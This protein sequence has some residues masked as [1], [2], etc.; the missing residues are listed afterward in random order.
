MKHNKLIPAQ[1]PPQERYPNRFKP[2][3]SGNPGG[4]PKKTAAELKAVE[5]M[6][7]LTPEAVDVVEGILKN[8]KASFYARLQAAQIIFDRAMGRPDTFLK[9]DNAEQSVAASSARLQ[10]LFGSADDD[11][12]GNDD[13]DVNHDGADD[14][15]G[16]EDE[17]DDPDETGENSNSE[18]EDDDLPPAAEVSANAG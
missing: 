18:G 3:T 11:E 12:D 8:S 13:N 4:R 5:K 6:K 2:G 10:S 7:K 16:D 1:D 17:A 9:V 15:E 14:D